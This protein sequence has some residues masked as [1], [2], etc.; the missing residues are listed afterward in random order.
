M[1]QQAVRFKNVELTKQEVMACAYTSWYPL[2][3]AFSTA[4]TLIFLS[5][6]FLDYLQDDSIRLPPTTDAITPDS[7]NEYSDWED[8]PP[9]LHG[10][11]K[12]EDFKQ[13][14]EQI[15]STLS[16]YGPVTPKLNWSAPVDASWVNPGN[17]T[18]CT[19]LNDVLLLLKSSNHIILDIDEPFV[20]VNQDDDDS[21]NDNTNGI[22]DNNEIPYTLTLRKWIDINPALEFRVFIH[23]K[24]II[25]IS[26]R[27]LNYYVFLEEIKEK[28]HSKI[29]D[30]SE[31]IIKKFPLSKFILDIYIPQPYTKTVLIDINPFSRKSSPLLFTWNELLTDNVENGQEYEFRLVESN[32]VGRFAKKEYSESQVPLDMI[33][34]AQN[35]EG[36]IELAKEWNKA[37]AKEE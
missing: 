25:G 34:A 31:K 12:S 23:D 19:L 16:K 15:N 14:E 20:E 10:Y 24:K 17:T 37:Q 22:N 11:F 35:T 36:L 5:T 7:D 13:L 28:L 27:D 33:N 8:E 32:N 1:T 26:Q 6:T 29:V 30:F 3:S 4:S 9:V 21:K 18:K 2:F